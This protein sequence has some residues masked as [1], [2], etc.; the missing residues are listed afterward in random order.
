MRAAATQWFRRTVL[1]RA[2]PGMVRI[3]HVELIDLLQSQR[4]VTQLE[5]INARKQAELARLQ[6]RT[7][8]RDLLSATALGLGV[9]PGFADD[10]LDVLPFDAD[11]ALHE[12]AFAAAVLDRAA[13][14]RLHATAS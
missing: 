14:P 3:S 4:R 8:A 5:E 6:A 7:Q 9:A 13:D 2:D 1:R 10:L 12:P 11:G